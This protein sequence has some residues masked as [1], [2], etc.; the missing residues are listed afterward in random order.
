MQTLTAYEIT[1]TE[2]YSIWE[3]GSGYSWHRWGNDTDYY[4][5]YGREIKI[6]VPDEYKLQESI[7]GD[8]RLYP[9][10]MDAN[11]AIYSGIA[12]IVEEA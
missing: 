10:G 3:Q 12:Q 1:C 5:G 4:K 8:L 9:G 2:S 6:A 7:A 11:E